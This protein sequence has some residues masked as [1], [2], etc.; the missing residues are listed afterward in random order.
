MASAVALLSSPPAMGVKGQGQ[1]CA[2]ARARAC[3]RVCKQVRAPAPPI[4]PVSMFTTVGSGIACT[5]VMWCVCL[6][7]REREGLAERPGYSQLA[8]GGLCRQ[9]R[10]Q[11]F[12]FFS[13]YY[14]TGC[15][16]QFGLIWP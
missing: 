8:H 5:C 12:F 14:D 3:V 10:Q 2:R 16:A 4:P 15:V 7:Q 13:F 9:K 11:D 1:R 6:A